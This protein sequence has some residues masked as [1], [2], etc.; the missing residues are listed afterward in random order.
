MQRLTVSAHFPGETTFTE[1][2]TIASG[3]DAE[4]DIDTVGEG[5]LAPSADS[6]LM[7]GSVIWRITEGRGRF[8]GAS[9]L[10]TS[11]FVLRPRRA[12]WM[13]DGW[14]H[15]LSV[16]STARAGRA[17]GRIGRDDPRGIKC[18]PRERSGVS[19]ATIRPARAVLLTE[20][21]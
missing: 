1:T 14:R 19:V 20:R 16:S 7:H 6:E 17:F 18:W 5:T 8:V 12:R 9:A 4:L 13:T 21:T 11:N 3:D 15:V 10:I 2:G